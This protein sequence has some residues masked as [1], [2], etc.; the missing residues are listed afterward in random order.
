MIIMNIIEKHNE[1]FGSFYPLDLS[2]KVDLCNIGTDFACHGMFEYAVG[3][4]EELIQNNKATADVYCNL[5]VSYFYGNGVEKDEEKAVHYYQ[6]AAAKGHPFG[7][8]NYAVALEQGNGVAK[9]M[10]KA[11]HFYQKAAEKHV[12]QAI[13]ALVRL[14]VYN[15]LHLQHYSRNINDSSFSGI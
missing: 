5:G 7:Q 1:I 10:D 9:D 11:I 6:L 2:D 12:N 13:D 15:E 4:W 3:I 8:Y 14:G